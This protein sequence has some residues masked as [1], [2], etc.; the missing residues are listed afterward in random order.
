[1]QRAQRQSESAPGRAERAHGFFFSEEIPYGM[2]LMRMVLPWTLMINII[3]R[4]PW[5]REL[6]STDGAPAP[7]ADN[8]GVP[9]MLPL[10]GPT[11]AVALY[12]L[13]TSTLV[14]GSVGWCTRFS[15]LVACP[16]YA[17]FGLIDCMSTITKYTVIATHLL[18]LL[19]LSNAGKVWSVDAWLARRGNGSGPHGDAAPAVFPVWPQRLVQLFIGV[20][21]LGAAM[22]KIHTPAFFS[23]DQ[24]MYWT[25]T[26]INNVHPLG[27]W[28]SQYPLLLS[29][30][31]YITIVWEIVFIFLVF[32]ARLRLPTLGVG[33]AFH[34]MTM[35]TLGLY[36]FPLVMGASYLAFLT[37]AEVERLLAWR[38]VR[39][40][41]GRMA[42]LLSMLRIPEPSPSTG[43]WFRHRGAAAGGA[44]LL[45]CAVAAIELEYW[46][47]PYK[48]RGA[49]GPLPLRA[50]EPEEAE[51]M[52]TFNV[53]LRQSDKVL[54]FDLGTTLVGEHLVDRR[55]EFVQGSALI[56]QLTLS[57]PHE[58]MWVDC[59]L[60][61]VR[62]DS[63]T[64]DL[65]PGRVV[66]RTGHVVAR[67]TFRTS[68]AFA[69]D[70][71]LPPA[72]YIVRVRAG[73]EEVARRRFALKSRTG[74]VAAN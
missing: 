24:L 59:T 47:D 67:E 35:F 42:R 55:R 46:S 66:S 2:A 69:L 19:A 73:K 49:N 63:S 21:Y 57:P 37:Q 10:F 53:P 13:L 43:F 20:V 3:Q 50:L 11:M 38:P 12:A 54:A 51:R 72:N 39:A 74:A 40:A 56:A 36:V 28:L 62:L 22:T 64:G 33:L 5:V 34:L 52:F 27:D 32:H 58:D 48:M 31:G 68:F 70:E 17:Y 9:G 7:L 6:Y 18:L 16:L 45:V 8:F 30:F 4:W 29:I 60:H 23:G 25:M 71:H 61:E 41:T 65:V 26:Y 1:M 15:F 14:M 44:T